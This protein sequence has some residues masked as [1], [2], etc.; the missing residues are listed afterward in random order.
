MKPKLISTLDEVQN[1]VPVSMAS[2][3]KVVEP[4]LYTA[5]R[6]YIK[7]LIGDAQYEA[8]A[9]A[10]SPTL[11]PDSDDN[12]EQAILLAQRAIANLGYL[13]ALPVLSVSIGSAGIQISSTSDT[14][15][16]FQWQVEDIKESLQELGFSAIEDLLAYLEQYPEDFNAYQESEQFKA[17]QG[18]LIRS[19]ADFNQYYNIGSSR[20]VFQCILSIQKRV[21]SQT[22]VRILGSDYYE[23]LKASDLSGK[24]KTLVEQHLKPGLALLTVSKALVERVV[25]LEAGKVA[26]NFRGNYNNIKES[27]PAERDQLKEI[28]EQLDSDGNEYLSTGMEY[29]AANPEDFEG[30]VPPAGR[31]RAKFT[32][33]R[34][35]GIFGI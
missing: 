28:R 2:D 30:F 27:M 32:N 11:N 29:I 6:T 35:K 9:E 20:Y 3:I 33:D 24:K 7:A 34:T 18:C 12:I 15:N 19:A 10:Y 17:L 13:I 21:E 4:Y 22:L 26:F 8:L 1:V 5:E 16:A 23:T 14:K 31:R 25:T